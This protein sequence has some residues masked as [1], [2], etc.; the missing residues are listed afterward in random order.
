MIQNFKSI[1][2]LTNFS[3]NLVSDWHNQSRLSPSISQRPV[4]ELVEQT[5][6]AVV[7]VF[8][9]GELFE[10]IRLQFW[11]ELLE[12]IHLVTARISSGMPGKHIQL[13]HFAWFGMER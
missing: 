12:Q 1:S 3:G 13:L 2:S 10:E 4:I 5:I 9:A 11:T 6:L 8:V 7:S